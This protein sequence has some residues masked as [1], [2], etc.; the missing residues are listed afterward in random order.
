LAVQHQSFILFS[1]GG[2]SWGIVAGFLGTLPANSLLGTGATAG[3]AGVIPNSTF[4][5]PASVNTAIANLVN[6]SP[7]VLDTLGELAAALGNDPNFATTITNSLALK[8][9]LIS[10]IFTTPALGTPS[11]G[12]L[13]NTTG[14]PL[15][16]GV[17]GVLSIANGGT[18]SNTQNFVDLSTTQSIAGIKTFTNTTPAT[19]TTSAGT[20]FLGGI[21][22]GN[23]K[24]PNAWLL[25]P[26]TNNVPQN[27]DT[28]IYNQFA[29]TRWFDGGG[30]NSNTPSGVN[31]GMLL[32]FD[33]LF[34]TGA[35]ESKYRVQEFFFTA[36]ST[37]ARFWKRT[38]FNGSWGTWLELS[39]LNKT[40]TF[41]AI[42]N[43]TTQINIDGNKVLGAR[44]TGWTIGTGTPNKGVFAADT[45]TL[46]QVSQR[47]LAVEYMLRTMGSIN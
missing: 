24:V 38:E 22:A 43:F 41:T 12:V 39:F 15:P 23:I 20:V 3:I 17:T 35:T 25:E 18:G 5:T 34:G 16:T 31:S 21:G 33:S 1:L 37:N 2:T 28:Q 36:V 32:Q 6:S 4:A 11:S 29:G 7:A 9:N 40:Q 19:S 27:L 14:L 46:L 8:A 45:A 26:R 47:L 13:T 30:T 44:D 10:P 42:Q